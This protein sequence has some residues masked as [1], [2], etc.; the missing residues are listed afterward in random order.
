[1]KDQVILTERQLDSL[2]PKQVRLLESQAEQDVEQLNPSS[3]GHW[4]SFDSYANTIW[5]VWFR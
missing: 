5:E 2:G 1:M 4:N 3:S